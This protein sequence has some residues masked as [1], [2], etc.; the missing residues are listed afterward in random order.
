MA[1][2]V[3]STDQDPAPLVRDGVPVDSFR[4]RLGIIRA[5]K[6][7]NAK[8]AGERTGVGAENWRLWEKGRRPQDYEEACRKIADATELDRTWVASGG[9]LRNRWFHL[10]A[11]PDGPVQPELPGLDP[12]DLHVVRPD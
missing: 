9:P 7:W 12:P 5:L 11:P 3:S 6:G 4:V 2:A 10:V 8:Q 1:V